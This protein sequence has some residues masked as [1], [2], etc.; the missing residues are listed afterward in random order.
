[1]TDLSEEDSKHI[2]L[3]LDFSKKVDEAERQFRLG[4][5][6]KCRDRLRQAKTS[7]EQHEKQEAKE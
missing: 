1:M 6:D 4:N 5:M 3:Y 2:R 7:I